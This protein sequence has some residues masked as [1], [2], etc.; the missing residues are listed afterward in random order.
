MIFSSFIRNTDSTGGGREEFDGKTS[1]FN[2]NGGS[3]VSTNYPE[4]EA[5]IS[6][7]NREKNISK[8]IQYI[9]SL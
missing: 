2:K 4:N 5:Q 9:R 1:D 6:S 8:L 3:L 7:S